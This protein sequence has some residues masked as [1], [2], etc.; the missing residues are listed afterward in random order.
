MPQIASR[1]RLL[2]VPTQGQAVFEL[3]TAPRP[4]S[5]Q[6]YVNTVSYVGGVDYVVRGSSVVWLDRDFSLDG[7]DLVEIVYAAG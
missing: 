1:R 7:G 6:F 4:E 2:A 5:V 3:P